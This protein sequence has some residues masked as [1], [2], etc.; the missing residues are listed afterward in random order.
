MQSNNNI[1][2]IEKKLPSGAKKLIAKMTGKTENTVVAFFK[3][4]NKY[5]M[6]THAVIMDAAVKVIKELKARE[7]AVLNALK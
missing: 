5:H 3:G 7:E 2:E 1:V 6:S 4:D